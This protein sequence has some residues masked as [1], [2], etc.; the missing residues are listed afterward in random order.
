MTCN[1]SR[2]GGRDDNEIGMDTDPMPERTGLHG[3]DP[4]PP[5]IRPSHSRVSI[6]ITGRTPNLNRTAVELIRQSI[7]AAKFLGFLDPRIKSGGD[8]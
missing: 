2:R 7:F 4:Y 6:G 8:E 3:A 1:G 5:K